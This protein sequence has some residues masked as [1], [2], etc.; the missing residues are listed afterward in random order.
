[1][2]QLIGQDWLER[3]GAFFTTWLPLRAQLSCAAHIWQA[4]VVHVHNAD[5][6]SL[7]A[8]DVAEWLGLPLVFEIHGLV[9]SSQPPS[10]S[11][12]RS[13]S[14]TIEPALFQHADC[15][16]VQ[17][18]A[19]ARSVEELYGALDSRIVIMPNYV[20]YDR[21]DPAR[22]THLRVALRSQWGINDGEVV[23]LYAGYLNWYNGITQ[24]LEAIEHLPPRLPA[25]FIIC[26]EGELE[27]KVR[28]FTLCHPDRV[29]YLGQVSS[30]DMP[31]IYAASDCSVL[32][33]PDVAET[34]EATPMKLLEAMSMQNVVI[35]TRVEGMTRIADEQTAIFVTPDD[36]SELVSALERVTNKLANLLSLTQ[37]ARQRVIR[38]MG[39]DASTR[40]LDDIYA[41]LAM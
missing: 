19:M 20:D 36:R 23:F 18:E 31:G 26:G 12:R 9:G 4:G 30:D 34:R 13:R 7:A 14:L 17:T 15:V 41:S 39:V 10:G 1:M 27:D 32:P 38:Q 3:H 21:Y 11:F 25:R 28:Q 8:A 35:C 22:Y 33:R 6:I 16:I 2:R 24:L 5:L 29:D 40:K 37:H